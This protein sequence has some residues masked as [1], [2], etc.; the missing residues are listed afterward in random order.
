MKNVLSF[1]FALLFRHLTPQIA[2][3]KTRR[4]LK[5]IDVTSILKRPPI[6]EKHMKTTLR[7]L[8][9]L[10][11]LSVNGRT[12]MLP[13]IVFMIVQLNMKYGLSTAMPTGGIFIAIVFFAL[14][15]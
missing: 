15:R 11:T 2:L 5:G 9:L 3:A 1:I 14:Y 10:A 7:L 4:L 13:L 6:V 12:E 8:N